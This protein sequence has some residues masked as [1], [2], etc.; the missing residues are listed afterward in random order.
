MS[1]KNFLT[2]LTRSRNSNV[3]LESFVKHYLA[4]G[5]DEIYILDDNST[6]QIPEYVA[7]NPKV[8]IYESTCFEGPNV[9]PLQDTRLLYQHL[10]KDL[11]EWLIFVDIDEFI[12]TRRNS[13]KTIREEL[14]T[15]FKEADH[16]KVPWVL[17]TS[18]NKI[19]DPKQ[20]L[21]E[22]TWRWNHDKKHPIDSKKWGCRYDKIEVKS[23]FKPDKFQ[24][25]ATHCPQHP[26]KKINIVDGVDNTFN[27]ANVDETEIWYYNLREECI[28]RAYLVCN[29][30]RIISKNQIQQRIEQSRFPNDQVFNIADLLNSYDKSEIEDTFL[31][32]KAIKR[33]YYETN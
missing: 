23:I 26:I 20:I 9:V 19:K 8:F 33:K 16:I 15:T 30:Y 14:E 31:K 25:I 18:N 2:V 17:F 6:E 5:V 12:T 10:L 22:N 27:Y 28:N 4:E 7:N 29:H 3:F 24:S 32:E 21:L 11:T 1:K 13:K